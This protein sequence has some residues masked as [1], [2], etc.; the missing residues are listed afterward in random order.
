MDVFLALLTA[1][2]RCRRLNFLLSCITAAVSY[3]TALLVYQEAQLPTFHSGTSKFFQ[4]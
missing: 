2:I 4:V 1:K 3:E